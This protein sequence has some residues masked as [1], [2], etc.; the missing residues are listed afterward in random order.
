MK[1]KPITLSSQDIKILI[2]CINHQLAREIHA[3]NEGLIRREVDFKSLVIL[4]NK[5]TKNS[6]AK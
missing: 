2:V 6:E 4:K 1:N 3:L 5:L